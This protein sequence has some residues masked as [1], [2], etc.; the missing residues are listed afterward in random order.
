MRSAPA[1]DER[2]V[3]HVSC[4]RSAAPARRRAQQLPGRGAGVGASGLP[5]LGGLGLGG[6]RRDPGA[7]QH[8]SLSLLQAGINRAVPRGILGPWT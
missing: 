1:W 4:A 2:H 3:V 8:L 5:Q 7:G 6:Q